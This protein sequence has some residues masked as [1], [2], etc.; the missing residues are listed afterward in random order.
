MARCHRRLAFSGQIRLAGP[1]GDGELEEEEEEKCCSQLNFSIV[2]QQR[3]QV[4]VKQGKK[5]AEAEVFI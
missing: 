3:E 5:M 2:K 4:L 1:E